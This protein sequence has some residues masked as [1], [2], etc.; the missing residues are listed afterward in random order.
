MCDVLI[1]LLAGLTST[2]R[3]RASLRRQI[4]CYLNYYH[5]SR[6]HLSLGKDPS[7]GRAAEPPSLGRIVAAPKVGGLHHRFQIRFPAGTAVL[8]QGD[9]DSPRNA[10]GCTN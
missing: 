7:E 9:Q 5:G 10:M 1:S 6:S 3:T 2:L 8:S 4:A